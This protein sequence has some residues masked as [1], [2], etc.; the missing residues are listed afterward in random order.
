[1]SGLKDHIKGSVKMFRPKTLVDAIFLAKKEEA[2][3]LRGSSFNS[4]KTS[5]NKINIVT[6]QEAKVYTNRKNVSNSNSKEDRKPKSNLSRKEIMQR[7][8]QG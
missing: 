5:Q 7:R 8:A 6:S 3:V 2:R 1:M 4:T